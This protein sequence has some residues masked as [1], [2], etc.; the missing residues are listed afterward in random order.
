[1]K[2]SGSEAR[3]CSA[4]P[5]LTQRTSF[6]SRRLVEIILAMLTRRVAAATL[7]AELELAVE[8]E[9]ARERRV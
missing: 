4:V 2:G 7:A 6:S 9:L 8:L 3:G 1:M 5:Y